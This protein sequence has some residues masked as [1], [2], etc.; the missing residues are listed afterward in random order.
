VKT[1]KLDAKLDYYYMLTPKSNINVTLGNTNSHQNFNSSIFQIL[2]NGDRN[3]LVAPENNNKVTYDFNDV[4][5]GLHYKFLSGKFTFTPGF[6]A[7]YYNMDNAQLGTNYKQ[8]FSKILPDFY[9][10]YQI[11]KSETLTYTFALNNN[12]T[13]INNLVMGNVLS[14]YSSLYNG[15]RFLENSTTQLHSLRYFKYSMYN[16]E[17]IFANISYSKVTDAVKSRIVFDNVNQT[18]TPYNSNLADETISANGAYGRSFLRF[19]KV[20]AG[21]GLNWSKFNNIQNGN[22]TT[23]ESFMQNYTLRASTNYRALP[24]LEVGYNFVVNDY[25]GSK[26]YTDKPFAKLDYYFLDSFSFVAEY[27][28]YHYYNS[29]KTVENE[30]DFLNASLIYQKKNSKFEYKI[31]ATN[32]LNTKTLNDDSFNQYRTTTSQYRVQPRYVILTLKYNL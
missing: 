18:L 24:N 28:F 25:A 9:A 19:Y 26:F 6:S 5:V 17:N 22:V 10:L 21:I 15:N 8:N 13:D 1:N 29:S 27:E 30:Y 7:H 16:L 14:G 23:Q 11:K 3:N 2:D 4:F 12:F 32:I 20:S 31:G